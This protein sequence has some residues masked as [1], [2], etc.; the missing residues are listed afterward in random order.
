[1]V[2]VLT[3]ALSALPLL[4][5]QRLS[6]R[7]LIGTTAWLAEESVVPPVGSMFSRLVALAGDRCAVPWRPWPVVFGQSQSSSAA[8]GL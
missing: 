3:L 2:A 6:Q 1:M 7:V 8:E 4:L 5:R